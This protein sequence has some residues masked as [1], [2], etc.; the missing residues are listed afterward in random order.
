MKNVNSG[1]YIRVVSTS[2]EASLLVKIKQSLPAN[3]K[4]EITQV[5]TFLKKNLSC[6]LRIHKLSTQHYIYF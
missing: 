3:L 4:R 6:G 1:F 5:V 2:Q